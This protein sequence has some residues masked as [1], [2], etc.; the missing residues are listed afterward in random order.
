MPGFAYAAIAVIGA[1][2]VLNLVLTLAL[3][4]RLR[5]TQT[6]TAH[7]GGAAPEVL[8]APGLEVTGFPHVDL[9]AVGARWS[10]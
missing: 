7:D 1:V 9:T 10:C 3:A 8:P 5:E 2:A 6:A 4:R